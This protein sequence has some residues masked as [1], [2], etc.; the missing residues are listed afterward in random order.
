MLSLLTFTINYLCVTHLVYYFP[1]LNK[2]K[3]CQFCF[4]TWHYWCAISQNVQWDDINLSAVHCFYVIFALMYKF[5]IIG[6]ICLLLTKTFF[7]FFIHQYVLCLR[8]S[9]SSILLFLLSHICHPPVGP[10]HS[11]T[12]FHW[13]SAL[14]LFEFS[15]PASWLL[16]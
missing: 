15:T 3:V 14:Q 4:T 11:H 16:I 5:V 2:Y 1:L 9:V 13:S 12:C 8:P 7:A 10:A 6:K